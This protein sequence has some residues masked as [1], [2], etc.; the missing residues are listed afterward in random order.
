MYT[1]QNPEYSF[2]W[3]SQ[4]HSLEKYCRLPIFIEARSGV[5]KTA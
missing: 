1:T 5:T 3:L 4:M 2:I